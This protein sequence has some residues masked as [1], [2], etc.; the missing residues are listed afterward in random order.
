MRRCWWS[1][2]FRQG[3]LMFASTKIPLRIKPIERKY[4][5]ARVYSRA[6]TNFTL[7]GLRSIINNPAHDSDEKV[8]QKG[9]RVR[10]KEHTLKARKQG[11]S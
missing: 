2:L 6:Y 11:R 3:T 7:I 9:A 8:L 1:D 10:M 5:Q 4:R